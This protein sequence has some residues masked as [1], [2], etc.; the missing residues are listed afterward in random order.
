[1]VF[2]F[3][4]LEPLAKAQRACKESHYIFEYNRL[5]YDNPVPILKYLG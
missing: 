4:E 1:V 5:L 3:Q 2:Y